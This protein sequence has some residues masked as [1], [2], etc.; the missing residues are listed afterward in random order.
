MNMTSAV[1]F[2]VGQGQQL[3]PLTQHR[4]VELLPVANKPLLE[5]VFDQLLAVGVMQI[6]VVVGNKRNRIQSYFGPTYRTVPVTYV[7]QEK[8]NSGEN[9]SLS[10]EDAGGDTTLVISGDRFIEDSVIADVVETHTDTSASATIGVQDQTDIASRAD[11][12]VRDRESV[13]TCDD[14]EEGPSSSVP[15]GVCVFKSEV[16]NA[17]REGETIDQ[18][19]DQL[20]T[21]WLAALLPSDTAVQVTASDG[22]WSKPESVWELLELSFEFLTTGI[23]DN[24]QTI[25]R[26]ARVHESAIIR[27][28]II[29]AE[30]CEIGA[31]AVVG[32]Y[33]CVGT[34][35]TI[36]PNATIEH[37]VV[38]VDARIRDDA[39]VT[40]SMIGPGVSIG[41]GTMIP[42]DSTKTSDDDDLLQGVQRGAVLGDRV[43]DHGSNTYASGIVVE[44]NTVMKSGTTVDDQM[45]G[46]ND[47]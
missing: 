31:E 13:A 22:I 40:G 8:L 5:H 33:A 24:G 28:P 34:N 45:S 21:E 18:D 38:D 26:S 36:H 25:A 4:P 42:V 17:I 7:S 10:S 32:P 12:T 14:S 15:S 2:A 9:T 46:G 11:A 30:D 29:I 3:R 23:V 39:T 43:V 6:T 1:V 41:P 35:A 44:P 16:F 20:P 47:G 19:Q 27:E 37:S